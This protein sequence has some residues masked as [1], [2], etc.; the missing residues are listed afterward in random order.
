MLKVFYFNP[1][2]TCCY[3]VWNDVRQCVIID[4]GAINDGERQR[5]ASF[6]EQ[7]QLSVEAILLTHGH[8]DHVFGLKDAAARWPVPV[9][10][11]PRD[12]SVFEGS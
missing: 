4:P 7:E 2:R 10:M 9:F 6:V 8:F 5:L 12:Q 11:S 3:V 1:L